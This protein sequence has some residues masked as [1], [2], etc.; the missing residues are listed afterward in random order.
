[1]ARTTLTPQDAP[2]SYAAAGLALSQVV[3]DVS[4]GNDFVMSGKDLLIAQNTDSAAHTVTIASVADQLGRLGSITAESIAAGAIHVFGPF[5][6]TGWSNAGKLQINAS[7]ATV[8][9]SILRVP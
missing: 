4:N 1:M 2:G 6:P 3:A 5:Q 7:D 9:F 8:K